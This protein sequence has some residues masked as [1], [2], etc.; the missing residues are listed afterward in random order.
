MIPVC[1]EAGKSLRSAAVLK[2]YK[3]TFA[4]HSKQAHRVTKKQ[5]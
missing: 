2:R 3:A 4:A 5:V 1:A